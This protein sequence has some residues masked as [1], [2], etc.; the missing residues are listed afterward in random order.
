MTWE[1]VTFWH[2]EVQPIIDLHY[3]HWKANIL[4]QDVRADVGWDW[5]RIFGLYLLH[6]TA[7]YI[8]ENQSGPAQALALAVVTADDEEIPI[9]LLTVVPQFQCTLDNIFGPRTFAWHLADAPVSFYRDKLKAQPVV[10]VAAALIDTAIQSGLDSG[11]NGS[12]LLHADPNGGQRLANFYLQRCRM[13]Q[14]SLDSPPL[15][16]FRRKNV[17]QYFYLSAAG[18]AAFSAD[19]HCRRQPMQSRLR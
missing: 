8:P 14:L 12:L 15:S 18:A 6:N 17:D 7:R 9:G 3:K 13:T 11:M 1:H 16:A 5:T 10:Q 19:F 2:T 4:P